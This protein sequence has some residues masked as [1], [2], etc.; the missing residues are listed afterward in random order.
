MTDKE[1]TYATFLHLSAGLRSTQDREG[2][3]KFWPSGKNQCVEVKSLP[4]EEFGEVIAGAGLVC[5]GSEERVWSSGYE[6]RHW[7]PSLIPGVG[8]NIADWPG[9]DWAAL[10][11]AHRERNEDDQSLY[12]SAA[13]FHLMGAS[14][15][16]M[17]ISEW[18]HQ[19]LLF[20]HLQGFHDR[21]AFRNSDHTN[22]LVDCHSFLNEVG[23]ARDHISAYAA[24]A[25][26]GLDGVKAFAK[27]AEKRDKLPDSLAAIIDTACKENTNKL[28]L[29]HIGKYRNEIV[30]GRPINAMSN[31]RFETLSYDFGLDNRI[32]G[33]KFD[34]QVWPDKNEDI[35]FDALR[36]FHAMLRVL[37]EFG[38]AVIALA[39][40]EPM[41]PEIVA[42]N[43][44]VQVTEIPTRR[45]QFP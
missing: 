17:H 26:G 12:S 8:A 7:N 37:Y 20:A 30:H 23:S 27:L 33:V 38:R 18:Y 24:K 4:D 1:R 28:N 19:M 36:Q 25:I 31:G 35:K 34:I 45:V 40:I 21:M 43:G 15:R 22:F 6:D 39:P 42:R 13:S 44:V 10:A 41:V 5:I 29:R 3:V 14:R 2:A 16:L 11:N 32:L 9:H